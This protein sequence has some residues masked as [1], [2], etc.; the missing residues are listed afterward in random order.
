MCVVCASEEDVLHHNRFRALT[1]LVF[2][3]LSCYAAPAVTRFNDRAGFEAQTSG[4]TTV[5]FENATQCVS[6]P[7]MAGY[8]NGGINF[9]GGAARFTNNGS[10]VPPLTNFQGWVFYSRVNTSIAT[11]RYMTATLPAG[12]Y[13]IGFDFGINEDPVTSEL[14]VVIVTTDGEQTFR[15]AGQGT[16]TGGGR[17]ITPVW[18]GFT[19]SHPI[20]HVRF[21]L[22]GFAALGHFALDNVVY[23]QLAP[24]AISGVLPG[25]SFRTGAAV[26]PNSWISIF[27]ERLSHTS[28]LWEGRDFSG[29]R[30][31]V[32]IDDVSVAIG[33]RPAYVAY[34]SP[35]QINV[36]TPGDL[37]EGR[38]VVEVT[39]K[40][41]RSPAATVQVGRLAPNLFMFDA[42]GRR[43]AAATHPNGAPVGR[44]DLYAGASQPARPGQVIS[45]WGTG[46]GRTDPPWPEGQ[47]LPGPAP[48]VGVPVVTIGGA[49]AVVQFAG[50]TLTGVTQFNVVVPDGVPD[51]DALLRVTLEGTET[52]ENAYIAVQR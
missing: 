10:C 21:T 41:V 9:N 38:A 20:T 24:P 42:A 23:G 7:D 29:A 32:G 36:L 22:P 6:L 30:L 31:P 26:S 12:T 2:A 16:G 50:L 8:N 5:T 1:A 25:G 4:R 27:G 52:Q 19:S 34:V 37:P 35:T 49:T 3:A 51:G 47:V 46:F 45:L 14:E 43:Y 39:R 44:T 13:A 48:L 33:G 11:Q 18:V 40:G 28:R 17:R 15:A